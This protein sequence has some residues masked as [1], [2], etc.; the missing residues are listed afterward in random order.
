MHWKL[1]LIGLGITLVGGVS[2]IF[3]LD[4]AWI[5]STAWPNLAL[6]VVGVVVCAWA[7]AQRPGGLTIA[8]LSIAGLVTVAFAVSL[9]VLMR[10]PAAASID[11]DGMPPDFALSNQDGREVRLSSFRDAGP[12]LLVFYRGHW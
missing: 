7:A 6:A 11:V 3:L 8:C 10:L 1:G 5:R 12:V 4:N 9:F 2:W